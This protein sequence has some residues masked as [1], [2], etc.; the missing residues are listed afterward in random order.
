MLGILICFIF[1]SVTQYIYG[2]DVIN[3]KIYDLDLITVSDYTVSCDI[4]EEVYDKFVESLNGDTE[5]ATSLFQQ[6]VKDTIEKHD[7]DNRLDDKKCRV[8]DIEFAFKGNKMYHLLKKRAAKL[9]KG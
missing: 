5:H 8:I 3:D 9:K 7:K 4:K 6:A 2:L 1:R